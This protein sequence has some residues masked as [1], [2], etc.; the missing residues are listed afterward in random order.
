[1]G[2]FSWVVTGRG[3]CSWGVIAVVEASV[4]VVVVLLLLELSVTSKVVASEVVDVEAVVEVEAVVVVV[5]VL[6]VELSVASEVVE[7]EVLLELSVTSTCRVVASEVVEVEVVASEVVLLLVVFF[8]A[9]VVKP[10]SS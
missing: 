7:V 1:M 8:G 6:L 5:V 3:N 2:F 4:V 10:A 9:S